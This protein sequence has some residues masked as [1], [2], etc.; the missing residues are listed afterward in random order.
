MKA[1]E[2]QHAFRGGVRGYL[3]PEALA[4]VAAELRAI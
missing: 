3:R 2:M 4:E 1:F